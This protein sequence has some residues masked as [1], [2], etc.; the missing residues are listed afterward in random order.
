MINIIFVFVA[1]A[2]WQLLLAFAQVDQKGFY[3][4]NGRDFEGLPPVVSL[5]NPSEYA[6]DF[7]QQNSVPITVPGYG[8]VIG[9]RQR[10]DDAPPDDK[11]R[12]SP[13]ERV[14]VPLLTVIE[15]LG[16]PYA[17]PPTG[18]LRF[19]APRKKAAW[20]RPIDAAKYKP[21]C[22]QPENLYISYYNL[23]F[24]EDCLFLNVFTPNVRDFLLETPKSYLC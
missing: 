21:A 18:E 14:N 8:Q 13:R 17:E 12:G 20:H 6:D 5:P 24:D 2:C 11:R 16:I 9:Y 15:F 3:S 10:L 7:Y 19:Q 23:F 1:V 4:S 22:S